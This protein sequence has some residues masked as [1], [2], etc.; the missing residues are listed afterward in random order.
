MVKRTL[1]TT[2]RVAR[3]VMVGVIG[4][5]LLLLGAV[6]LVTPGPALL[7]IPLGLAVLGLEFAWARL[8]LRKLRRQIE[9]QG[10]RIRSSWLRR[11]TRKAEAESG[12]EPGR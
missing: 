11:Q 4:F 12:K 7:V 10:G 1:E 3:R 8:W 5:T 2:Y 6:M 9:A